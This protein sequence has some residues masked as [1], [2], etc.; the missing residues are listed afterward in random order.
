MH[1]RHHWDGQL[2]TW[3]EASTDSLGYSGVQRQYIPRPVGGPLSDN[4]VVQV[5][6]PPTALPIQLMLIRH[7]R[8]LLDAKHT[9]CGWLA[10]TRSG[11]VLVRAPAVRALMSAGSVQV[12]CGSFHSAAVTSDGCLFTWGNGLC[13]KLGHGDHRSCSQPRK[14]PS[15][16]IRAHH[17]PSADIWFCRRGGKASLLCLDRRA[18][19]RQEGI[20]AASFWCQGP[21]CRSVTS[22][23]PVRVCAQVEAL[24]DKLVTQVACGAWHTAAVASPRPQGPDVLEGLPFIERLAVQHKLAAMYE[25]TE[26]VGR[27]QAS[28]FSMR[29][30]GIGRVR[31]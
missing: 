9:Q 15:S 7:G 19:I 14:V 12:S 1:S 24:K 8:V 27:Y 30:E 22:T 25:L 18:W 6:T 26:E 16:P 29:V 20:R 13:G 3:G 28:A 10:C 11:Q 21:W 4:V 5:K 23:D 17:S 2:L 31:V